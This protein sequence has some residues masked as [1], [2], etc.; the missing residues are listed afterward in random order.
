MAVISNGEYGVRPGIVFGYP[1]QTLADG[2][3]EIA[4]DLSLDN[5]SREMIAITEKELLEER[6][7]A[8][9]P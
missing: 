9:K 1:L 2:S 3:W 4:K 7:A 8:S 5:F 6:I